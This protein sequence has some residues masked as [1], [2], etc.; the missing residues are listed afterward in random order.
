MYNTYAGKNGF[1]IRRSSTKCRP[2]GTLYQKYIVCSSEGY[3][4]N[5][6]SNGTTRTGCGA[7]VQFKVSKEGI[8]VVQ[9]VVFEHNHYL[10]SPNKI[11]KI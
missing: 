5:E 7:R 6:S 11:K 9:K 1:S 10:A 2:D 3:G 8:W 4:R